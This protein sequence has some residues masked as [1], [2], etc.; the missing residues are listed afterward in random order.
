MKIGGV[1]A[2]GETVMSLVPQQDLLLVEAQIRP[3]D[4]DQLVAGQ[5][6]RIRLPSFDQRTTP[7]LRAQLQ[8]ISADL[9]Q[10]PVSGVMYYQAR[11][12]IPE[13]ELDKLQGKTLV[14]GMPVEVFATTQNRT[15][16]SYLLKPIR[17]QIAHALRE[18]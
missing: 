1:I 15:V 5:Q 9:W 2:P 14:P 16:L 10:D 6:A 8:T 11:L 13:A 12:T 3:I 17:D 7:E 18:R 4:I